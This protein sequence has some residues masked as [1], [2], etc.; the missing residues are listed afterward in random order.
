MEGIRASTE[1]KTSS[2]KKLPLLH[3]N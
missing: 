2:V 3:I 1:Q